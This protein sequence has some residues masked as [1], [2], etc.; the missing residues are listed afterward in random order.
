MIDAAARGRWLVID[1]L[2]RARLDRALGELS[3]FLAGVPVALPD[4]EADAAR[5]LADRRDGGGSRSTARRRW[6]GASPTSTCPP[7]HD[8]DLGARD[9]RRGRRRR[10]RGAP[11]CGG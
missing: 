6:C 7:P 1:E 9:R 10:D 5:R 3:S 8:A 4:G 11:P 2:D